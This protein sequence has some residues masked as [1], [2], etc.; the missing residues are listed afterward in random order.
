MLTSPTTYSAQKLLWHIQLFALK[1]EAANFAMVYYVSADGCEDDECIN[2]ICQNLVDFNNF[3]VFVDSDKSTKAQSS[4]KVGSNFSSQ[5]VEP[6][7]PLK[8]K[9]KTAFLSCAAFFVTLLFSSIAS[10]MVEQETRISFSPPFSQTM[11]A[12]LQNRAMAFPNQ[13]KLK[14]VYILLDLA[15]GAEG[16]GQGRGH[17]AGD[18]HKEEEQGQFGAEGRRLDKGGGGGHVMTVAARRKGRLVRRD[19]W[20]C[21]AVLCLDI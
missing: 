11:L 12:V 4:V 19:G 14:H 21:S 7:E 10:A 2:W 20:M 13:C 17:A 6:T 8:Q 16:G 3:A 18:Q 5:P 15:T 1:V 9:K